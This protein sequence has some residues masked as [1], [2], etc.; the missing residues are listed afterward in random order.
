[1]EAGFGEL[2]KST[3]FKKGWEFSEH[4]I[5]SFSRIVHHGISYIFKKQEKNIII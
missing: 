1:M 4:L 5:I 3:G 2:T